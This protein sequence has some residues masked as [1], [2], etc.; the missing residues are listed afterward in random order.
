MGV[1]VGW[2]YLGRW[3]SGLARGAVVGIGA[4]GVLTRTVLG[5]QSNG[6]TVTGV[7]MLRATISMLDRRKW[8]WPGMERAVP[9]QTPSSAL[10]DA[11]T[12]SEFGCSSNSGTLFS[13]KADHTGST[14]G[15][16]GVFVVG[17]GLGASEE[18][19]GGVRGAEGVR[20]KAHGHGDG[21]FELKIVLWWQVIG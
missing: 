10:G 13:A 12:G 18:A 2:G 6:V 14:E 15:E 20:D 8:Y 11:W 3:K 4:G 19:F 16:E 7:K 21:L 1:D 5:R 17:S 9:R